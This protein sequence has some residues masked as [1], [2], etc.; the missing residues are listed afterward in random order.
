LVA[1]SVMAFRLRPFLFVCKYISSC[2]LLL[3][4]FSR[5]FFK[6]MAGSPETPFAGC[7]PDCIFIYLRYPKPGAISDLIIHTDQ[8]YIHA[9]LRNDVPV[10]KEIYEK[11]A[12][13]VRYYILANNG[14]EDDAADILQETLIDIYNQAKHKQLQLTCPFEPFLLLLCKRK[15]LNELKKRERRP[16][17]KDAIDVSVGE[18]VFAL[19]EQCRLNGKKLEAFLECFEK[20]GDKCREIIKKSLSGAA[21]E[22]IAEELKVTYGYLRKKKSEC[23]AS[24][25]E[26]IWNKKSEWQQ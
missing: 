13:R 18:D 3:P 4:P 23:M 11:F 2:F 12:G 6:K 1:Y 8:R 20:L 10:V 15:W 14:T 26:M 25:V 21:Q 19:A 24:L 17:T 9:L 5:N 22:A 16:V 7:S